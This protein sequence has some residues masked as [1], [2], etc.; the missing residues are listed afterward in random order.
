RLEAIWDDPEWVLQEYHP[1]RRAPDGQV[2]SLGL[3]NHGGRLGGVTLRA[4]DSL[5]VS[6]RR[7]RLVPVTHG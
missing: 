5:V 4:G 6:A 2:L 3:Y 1:P 7:S